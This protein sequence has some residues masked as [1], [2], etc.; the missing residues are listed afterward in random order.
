[1]SPAPRCPFLLACGQ[2]SA[3]LAVSPEYSA[4]LSA[5]AV[6]TSSLPSVS[7]SV[8]D[9]SCCSQLLSAPAWH[10]P[11]TP[12][13]ESSLGRAPPQPLPLAALPSNTY[14]HCLPSPSKSP[15]L[16]PRQGLLGLPGLHSGP[17]HWS[18]PIPKRASAELPHSV[19]AA[20]SPLSAGAD[21]E[22]GKR[23]PEQHGMSVE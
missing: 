9:W 21:P 13:P 19:R 3:S 14:P 18:Q 10:C 23:T 11:H 8:S 6:P 16:A 15:L 7:G 17:T 5:P 4:L 2:P 20:V 1:M 12:W 22:G